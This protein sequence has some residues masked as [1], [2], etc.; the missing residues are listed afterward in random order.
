MAEASVARLISPPALIVNAPAVVVMLLSVPMS[1]ADCKSIEP[2]LSPCK[3]SKA[4]ALRIT[5]L[6]PLWIP[7]LPKLL[8]ALASEILPVPVS[9]VT[10][11][12]TANAVPACWTIASLVVANSKV[13]A[14]TSSK[15]KGVVLYTL[16][17]P[18][19]PA[20]FSGLMASWLKLLLLP[21]NVT[22]ESPACT[23][24]MP[25]AEMEPWVWSIGQPQLPTSKLK[26]PLAEI[27]S[28]SEMPALSLVSAIST[29]ASGPW[30][31]K[32]V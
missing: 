9:N 1:P 4:E 18:P 20:A 11:P 22:S 19:C 29:A 7:R 10:A 2:A 28:I 15:F 6:P 8:P 5:T 13:P 17:M 3:P 26:F 30:M 27:L 25:I 31:A 32:F 12:P 16:T 24:V 21:N 23:V 14:F